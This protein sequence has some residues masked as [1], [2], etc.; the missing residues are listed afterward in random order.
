MANWRPDGSILMK[1]GRIIY[2]DTYI[3]G[4]DLVELVPLLAPPAWPFVS[5]GGGGANGGVSSLRGGAGPQGNPGPQGDPGPPG[6]QGS[7]GP[8]G[9][10]GNQGAA[11][12]GGG[13]LF[14]SM[15]N[16]QMGSNQTRFLGV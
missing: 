7:V 13:I 11:G 10:Q 6:A 8:Q 5:G 12:T 9:D 4:R 1:D 15:G 14:T 16:S 3:A 2:G